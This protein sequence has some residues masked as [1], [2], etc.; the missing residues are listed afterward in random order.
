MVFINRNLIFI[1]PLVSVISLLELLVHVYCI[2]KLNPIPQKT[3]F[4][5]EKIIKKIMRCTNHPRQL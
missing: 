2:P 5:K 1:K 4:I 3:Y